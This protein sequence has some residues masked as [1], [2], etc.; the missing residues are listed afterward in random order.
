MLPLAAPHGGSVVVVSGGHG[1]GH[2]H[3]HKKHK[4]KHFGKFKASRM[5][6]SL[7]T[8]AASQYLVVFS[9]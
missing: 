5:G 2:K 8:L 9:H 6:C 7:A 1:H 4:H 3:K